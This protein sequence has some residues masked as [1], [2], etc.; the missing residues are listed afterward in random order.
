MIAVA[1]GLALGLGCLAGCGV[2]KQARKKNAF[3]A[4]ADKFKTLE[5]VEKG[6]RSAGLEASQLII[7]I[8]FTKSNTYNGEKSFGGHCLHEINTRQWNPYQRAIDIIGRTLEKFDDDKMIPVYGF[9][10]ANTTDKTVFSFN[11]DEAPCFGVSS[12]LSRYTEIVPH[13]Q[14]LGPT[15][16]APLIKKAI[17]I[18]K[19]THQYHIL[20]ILTDG[21]VDMVK[22]TT[23][24]IIE[25]SNY[26]LSIVVVGIGDADF[27][28][29]HEYD[30][31]LPQ[32]QFD[33]FQFVEFS[34][35][36]NN[37]RVENPEVA[38]AVDALQE[39]PDQYKCIKRLGLL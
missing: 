29:M 25:A 39:I 21:Q 18:V 34:S 16:F 5:E 28:R 9:G 19:E 14:L 33:N 12:V 37:P 38:F 32:R 7:G 13:L 4:I 2:K 24:A 1:A 23:A 35:I 10:D 22:E 8:D 26:A 17:S 27:S 20:L 31:E 15:S 3:V 6:L 36:I 11:T 30:D